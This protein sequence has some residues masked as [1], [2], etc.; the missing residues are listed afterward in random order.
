MTSQTT[1]LRA[2]REKRRLTQEQLAMKS[3]V[4]RRAIAAIEAGARAH[5][6]IRRRLLAA[7]GLHFSEHRKVFGETVGERRPCSTTRVLEDSG[8]AA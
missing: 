7:L 2:E 8:D 3:G 6:P 5:Q 1:T 4:S